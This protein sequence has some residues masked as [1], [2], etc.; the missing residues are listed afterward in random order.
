MKNTK[1]IFLSI[2][3]ITLFLASQPS[4]ASASAPAS[5]ATATSQEPNFEI[6]NK[7]KDDI[8]VYLSYGDYKSSGPLMVKPQ[9]R[10]RYQIGLND[11]CFITINTFPKDKSKKLGVFSY[12]INAPGKTK[13]VTW[14]P[15]KPSA[16][17]PQTGPLAGFGRLIGMKT[18]SG[19]SLQ[20]NLSA[21][22][23]IEQ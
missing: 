20:N 4:T 1:N 5:R 16:L 21:S 18:E 7:S 11:Q 22:Q 12:K 19:L 10:K 8:V 14:N 17:Y 2:A 6:S 9:E 15:D 23:I 3:V 13:Y